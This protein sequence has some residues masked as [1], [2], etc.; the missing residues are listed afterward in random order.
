MFADKDYKSKEHEFQDQY[1]ILKSYV[2]ICNVKNLTPLV[3]FHPRNP[4]NQFLKDHYINDFDFEFT[5]TKADAG[6]LIK[7]C[8]LVVVSSSSLAIDTALSEKPCCHCLTAFYESANICASAKDE[9]QLEKFIDAPYVFEDANLRAATIAERLKFSGEA[10][11]DKKSVYR[12]FK[13]FLLG[14]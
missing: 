7:N 1:E 6:D 2:K 8:E 14:H 11:K 9:H 13:R 10:I 5:E 4:K 12:Y 3:K